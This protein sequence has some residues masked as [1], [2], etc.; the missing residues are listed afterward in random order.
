[1][2]GVGDQEEEQQQ[3]LR[4]VLGNPYLRVSKI[5][6][7]NFLS[8]SFCSGFRIQSFRHCNRCRHTQNCWENSLESELEVAFAWL[9][10]HPCRI[11]QVPNIRA[12]EE[13]SV[14]YPLKLG[15]PGVV[16]LSLLWQQQGI[17]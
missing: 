8:F 10:E 2:V 16:A 1:M 17:A 9:W 14:D 7:G 15:T 11:D 3:V 6:I 13:A 4:L 12:L 5:R